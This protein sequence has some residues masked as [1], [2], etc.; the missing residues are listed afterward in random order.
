MHYTKEHISTVLNQ[1]EAKALME[2]LQGKLRENIEVNIPDVLGEIAKQAASRL[3]EVMFDDELF[4]KSP[5]QVLDRGLDVLKGLNHL[6]GG[7][8]GSLQPAG[9]STT[10]IGTVVIT[11]AQRSDLLEGLERVKEV[12]QLHGGDGSPPKTRG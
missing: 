9:G 6:R 11:Q 10:N 1:P 5:F 12:H 3:K 4:Q 2:R 7:G 8:N